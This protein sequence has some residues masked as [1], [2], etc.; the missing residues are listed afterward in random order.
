MKIAV[1]YES[2]PALFYAYLPDEYDGAPD[3]GPQL[4][5]YGKTKAEALRELADQIEERDA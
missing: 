5:G 1:E 2:T 3:A 4:I